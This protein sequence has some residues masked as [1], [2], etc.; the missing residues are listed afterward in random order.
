MIAKL[1]RRF[2]LHFLHLGYTNNDY[3]TIQCPMSTSNNGSIK[4]KATVDRV[5]LVL[6][7]FN[8]TEH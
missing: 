5:Y 3:L 1:K 8:F 2:I 4:N 6:F 7:Q